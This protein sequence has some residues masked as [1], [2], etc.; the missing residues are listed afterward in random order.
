MCELLAI[1]FQYC[2]DVDF[3][4]RAFAMRDAENADGWGLAW[5]PDQSLAL[6]KEPLTWRESDYA[7]FLQKYSHLHSHIYIGHVRK[8]TVGG[9]NTHADTHPFMRELMGRDYCFT[10]NGTVYGAE[11]LPVDRFQPTGA[12]DSERVFCHLLQRIADRGKHLETPEDWQWLHE[13]CY[14]YNQRG[15]FNCQLT[16]GHRVISYHDVNAFK[17]MWMELL[18]ARPHEWQR[19]DDPTL[20]VDVEADSE[21]RGVVIASLPLNNAKWQRFSPTEMVVVEAGAVVYQRTIVEA[22]SDRETN[23][24][25]AIRTSQDRF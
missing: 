7:E 24:R 14:Q 10:H 4:I 23:D 16:D 13:A 2:V 1:D 18:V 5:Y 6:A 21:N 15:K 20:H 9:E 3:S 25:K 19:F 12:T 17:G 11:K 22:S 8:K